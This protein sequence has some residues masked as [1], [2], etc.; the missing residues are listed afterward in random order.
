MKIP[1][2]SG[3]RL[4]AGVVII[5][6]VVYLLV[7]Q[8][9]GG[10]PAHWG[11][12]AAVPSML[13]ILFSLLTV[14]PAL[15]ITRQ[16]TYGLAVTE[17]LRLSEKKYHDLFVNAPIGIF[18]R[19]LEGSYIDFN[20][21]IME[22]FQC[23][24]P[25]DFVAHYSDVAN[26]WVEPEELRQF[27]KL[28]LENGA[29]RDFNLKTQ[30]CDGTIKWFSLYAILDSTKLYFN[31][32]AVDIT[33]R[34]RAEEELN[35]YREHLESLV[36]DRTAELA[37]AVTAAEAANQAKSEFLANMSHE[38]RT[39]LNAVVGMTTMLLRSDLD[40]TQRRYAET[41]NYASD[42]LLLQIDNLLDISR[43]EEG[44]LEIESS[45]FDLADTVAK[46]FDIFSF[47]AEQK[48]VTLELQLDPDLSL[49]LTGDPGRLSQIMVN[50]LGNAVKFT[51]Q[52][53]VRLHIS[54]E[55]ADEHHA[56]LRFAVTD[57]GIGIAPDKLAHIFEP[58]TQADSSTT[59]K[60]GGTGLGLAISKKLVHLM[61]GEIGVDS[62]VGTGSTFWFVL[63]LGKQPAEPLYGQ[64]NR[65][66][67]PVPELLLTEGKHRGHLLLAE[68]DPV[69]QQVAVSYLERLGYS[70]DIVENGH[71]VLQAL[72]ERDYDLVLMDF[73]MSEMGGLEATAM[74]RDP[75]FQVRNRTVPIVALTARATVGDR[76]YCLAAGMSD[77][78]TKPLRLEALAATLAKWLPQAPPAVTIG[79]ADDTGTSE[80][81]S[82]DRELIE[83]FCQ[84]ASGYI[85]ALERCLTEDDAAGVEHHAHKLVG[86]A[87]AIGARRVAD[88]GAEMEQ[89]GIRREM[90]EA[91][92]RQQ[93]LASAFQSLVEILTLRA[94]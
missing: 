30:L 39:P 94:E 80:Q 19:R 86:A 78:L 62:V 46:I 34:K 57:S 66:G 74:I 12:E 75:L 10:Y 50:L 23:R 35:H 24:T 9:A 18:Q 81:L 27:N 65:A 76:E 56:V 60:Y 84:E 71:E 15:I 3:V 6:F 64:V 67:A 4:V 44:K 47:G 13:L 59:R 88:L 26:R 38:M 17:A 93:Q 11:K 2:S 5:N 68:D 16:R 29:V 70:F 42:I 41:V 52:G 25:E 83:L 53:F 43:I 40:A 48:G 37:L 77:Y 36:K 89:L 58:F 7:G 63:P 28:L 82:D 54:A 73:M 49:N 51:D 31:G 45:P 1:H 72:T 79:A 33:E 14:L 61:G 21:V 87:R 69:N 55:A 22:Q 85:A 8:M 32:F 92:Q 20:N 90:A 91:R